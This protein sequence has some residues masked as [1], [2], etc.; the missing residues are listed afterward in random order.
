MKMTAFV[1]ISFTESPTAPARVQTG[2]FRQFCLMF[3]GFVYT[4]MI[5]GSAVYPFRCRAGECD[6]RLRSVCAILSP[7]CVREGGSRS[8]TE[9]LFI[10]I[11]LLCFSGGVSGR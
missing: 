9:G 3:T 7:P 4:N 5:H 11:P 10:S 8:E 2:R 1:H 6:P